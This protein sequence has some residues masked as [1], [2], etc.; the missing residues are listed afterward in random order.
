MIKVLDKPHLDLT[1]PIGRGFIA[2]LSALAGSFRTSGPAGV[3]APA[4]ALDAK[5]FFDQQV[6]TKY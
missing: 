2:F 6:R 4:S 3:A 5:S 1:T